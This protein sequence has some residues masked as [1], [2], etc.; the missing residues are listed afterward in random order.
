M[1][2]DHRFVH[3]EVL[4]KLVT[5]ILGVSRMFL[6]I[7]LIGFSSELDSIFLI[8]SLIGFVLLINVF[9]ELNF[10]DEILKSTK[11]NNQNSYRIYWPYILILSLGYLALTIGYFFMN[12]ML[13]KYLP[14]IIIFMVSAF[15]NIIGYLGLVELRLKDFQ[16]KILLYYFFTSFGLLIFY[17]IF[18]FLI[19][20]KEY[21][22][23]SIPLSVL[24]TDILLIWT[25]FRDVFI[26][27]VKNFSSMVWI[28]NK[29]LSKSIFIIGIFVLIDSTDKFFLNSFEIGTLSA[30]NYGLYFMLLVRS[31][32]D[33]RSNFNARL[34]LIKERENDIKVLFYEYLRILA[35]LYAILM[36][37]FIPL[38]IISLLYFSSIQSVF[39]YLKISSE[40]TDLLLWTMTI[41][42][43]CYAPLY[44]VFDLTYRIYYAVNNI[45]YIFKASISAFILNILFNYFFGVYL[46]FGAL[47]ILFSSITV[48]LYLVSTGLKFIKKLDLERKEI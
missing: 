19:E 20:S 11:L 37:V 46:N 27:F 23:Y 45:N 5:K 34:T 3:F 16:P 21:S 24:A 43:I 10:S 36:I 1:A 30:F 47:G 7:F 4:T 8:Q 17:L 9:F 40:H 25:L 26:K 33:I 42:I 14:V 18:Y 28:W 12:E 35:K 15:L 6:I 38:I 41:G 22:F 48:F 44:L 2:L 32:L 13:S 29:E 39:E 31:I